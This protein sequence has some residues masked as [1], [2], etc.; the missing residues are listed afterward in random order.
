[1]RSQYTLCL[2]FFIMYTGHTLNILAF[3]MYSSST[4]GVWSIAVFIRLIPCIFSL[5]HILPFS[6]WFSPSP[7][8]LSYQSAVQ[9]SKEPIHKL[10]VVQFL[11]LVKEVAIRDF[12]LGQ[13]MHSG[14][15]WVKFSAISQIINI[16]ARQFFYNR[17]LEYDSSKI[18]STILHFSTFSGSL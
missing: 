4:V 17:C 15:I 3:T 14:T 1:M 13:K 2:E 9:Q 10:M 11:H 16:R 8:P 12:C 18:F 5:S 7:S 6:D